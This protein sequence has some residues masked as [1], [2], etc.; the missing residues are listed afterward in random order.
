[1]IIYMLHFVE[2]VLDHCPFW[3]ICLPIIDLVTSLNILDVSYFLVNIV[4]HSVA[5]LFQFLNYVFWWPDL[6]FLLKSNLLIYSFMSNVFWVLP[7]KYLPVPGLQTS[8]PV[9]S[10]IIS[11]VI[12]KFYS[13]ILYR[14]Y[15][16][17]VNIKVDI[18]SSFEYS[19]VPVPFVEKDGHFNKW[20]WDNWAAIWKEKIAFIPYPEQQEI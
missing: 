14:L 13:E 11:F 9:F 15:R 16:I 5:C 10:F 6:K 8:S 2:S 3:I 7:E 20:C 17:F 4:S 19:V 12:F 18:F 1:M